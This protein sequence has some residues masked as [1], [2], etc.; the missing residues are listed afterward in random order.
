MLDEK[1]NF[2]GFTFIINK[3]GKVSYLRSIFGNNILKFFK[4]I[5]SLNLNNYDLVISDFEPISAWA[6][7]IKGNHLFNYH[8]NA[9]YFQE[10]VLVQKN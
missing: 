1:Y 5:I 4:D 8:I 10:K 3:K 7:K 6:S 9:L 2:R